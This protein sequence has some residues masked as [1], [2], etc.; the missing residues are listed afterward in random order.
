MLHKIFAA[1]AMME[2]YGINPT[3]IP[4][5][6]CNPLDLR[7]AGQEGATCP[8]CT[9]PGGSIECKS[10][11][12][13]IALFVS[14]GHGIAAGYRQLCKWIQEGL[15]LRKIVEIHAPPSEN[16]TEHYIK[17]V[18]DQCGLDSQTVNNVPVYRLLTHP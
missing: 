2:G 17:V 18:A 12:H 5:R 15:T 7:Y 16:D 13:D 3:N 6:R 11:G 9:L 8:R 4:T 14:P 1:M 10:K